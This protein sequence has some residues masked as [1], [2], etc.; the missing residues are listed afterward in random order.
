DIRDITVA[1]LEDFDDGWANVVRKYQHHMTA[2]ELFTQRLTEGAPSEKMTFNV[3]TD[4]AANTVA[5]TFFD[6]D[7][8][9]RTD[10]FRKG[11]VKWHFQKT[12][13]V[14]DR[15]EPVLRSGDKTRIFNYFEGLKNDMYD[16]FF[17]QN[18]VWSWTNPTAPNDG[19]TGKPLPFGIPHW[20][21][22]DA[23]IST[24]VA[25]TADTPTG[26]WSSGVG[27]ITS[28]NVPFWKNWQAN[29]SSMDNDDFCKKLS[30]LMR[31]C[32]FK[33]PKPAKEENV[34]NF[35]KFALYSDETPFEDYEDALYGSNENVGEDMGRW[36]GGKP[37]TE[38]GTHIFRGCKWRWVPALSEAG[39]AQLSASAVYAINWE[40]FKVNSYGDLFMDMDDPLVIDSQHNTLVQWM[41]TGWQMCCTNRRANGVLVQA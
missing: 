25:L 33:P 23:N 1:Y 4:E 14:V 5:D 8:L 41:D 38:V 15:R 24:T 2:D 37:S 36:R 16:G 30:S 6:A 22:N 3:K 27:N 18:E 11:E 10:L 40:T 19:T 35:D 9:N 31:K 17:E 26:T 28:A 13:F 20:I 7:D 21:V 12:H 32:H 29:Y 34:A 39:D